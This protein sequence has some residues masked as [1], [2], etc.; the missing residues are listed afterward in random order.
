MESKMKALSHLR[1]SLRSSRGEELP[2]KKVSVMAPT[3]EGLKE[4]LQKAE[5]ILPK[6][7][8]MIP[9]MEES[10]C[11]ECEGCEKCEGSEEYEKSEESSEGEF[12]SL[13]REELISMIKE[14][15]ASKEY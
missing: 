5:E 7:G 13:S 6:I 2:M 11:S 3:E 14:L 1:K 4:G 10:E 9:K 15:K 12:E 8:K